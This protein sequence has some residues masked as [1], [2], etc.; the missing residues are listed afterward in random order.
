MLISSVPFRFLHCLVLSALLSFGSLSVAAQSDST[1]PAETLRLFASGLLALENGDGESAVEIWT[2]LAEAGSSDALYGLGLLY[3][4]G[5]GGVGRDLRKAVQFYQQAADAGLPEAQTN[6]GLMYADG[7][8]VEKNIGAAVS[9]W[10]SAAFSGHAMAQFNLGLAYYAG[11]GVPQSLEEAVGL[12]YA[13]AVADM[14][15]AQFAL[16]QFY[17]L[18]LGVEKSDAEAYFWFT[19]AEQNGNR[20]ARQFTKKFADEKV[21]LGDAPDVAF[22]PLVPIALDG[23]ETAALFE[24]DAVKVGAPEPVRVPAEGETLTA[25][26]DPVDP[27]ATGSQPDNPGSAAEPGSVAM[28]PQGP[29][30][31]AAAVQTEPDPGSVEIPAAGPVRDPIPAAGPVRDPLAGSAPQAA[32]PDPAAAPDLSQFPPAERPVDLPPGIG[33]GLLY[34]AWLGTAESR[35][36]LNRLWDELI[37]LQPD[38][39]TQVQPGIETVKIGKTNAYRLL[40]GPFPSK[41]IAWQICNAIKIGNPQV[42]CKAKVLS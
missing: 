11:N 31:S 33:R 18:G 40:I 7:K 3:E 26:A 20:R 13:A 16:A 35:E 28:P 29:L 6:L 2:P 10:Q 34:S 32:S 37:P 38:I 22:R 15:D 27:G 23:S 36:E 24:S 5:E 39:F 30:A 17:R 1:D 41:S 12:I 21:A 25:A 14:A 8:G 4:N 19:R 9:L 42:F